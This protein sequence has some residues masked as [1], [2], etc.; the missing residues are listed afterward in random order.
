MRS[1]G[2]T[3]ALDRTGCGCDRLHDAETET[4]D[5]VAAGV[6]ASDGAILQAA[7]HCPTVTKREPDETLLDDQHRAA[8]KRVEKLTGAK[9]STCPNWYARS[10]AA[11]E[12]SAAR[13]WRDAGQLRE[14]VGWPSTVLVAAMDLMDA[15]H[16]ARERDDYE[17][18]KR[19]R[20]EREAAR[21]AE[22]SG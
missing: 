11:H 1:V 21:K 13:R 17:R 8:L 2:L 4:D 22:S 19:E 18:D 9:C 5:P 6:A 12:V 15:A 7:W 10:Q 3:A 20:E 14:R 16:N